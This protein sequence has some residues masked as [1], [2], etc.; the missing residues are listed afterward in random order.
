M[1]TCRDGKGERHDVPAEVWICAPGGK[2]IGAMCRAHAAEVI[3]EY[4]AKLGEEWTTEPY[5][6]PTRGARWFPATSGT[7]FAGRPLR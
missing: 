3:A 2:R 5:D 4:R 6:D 7:H 1:T